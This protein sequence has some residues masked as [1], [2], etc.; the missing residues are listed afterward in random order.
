MYSISQATFYLT[1]IVLLIRIEDVVGENI[2]QSAQ[3]LMSL[4]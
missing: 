1:I 4:S 2:L 3:L